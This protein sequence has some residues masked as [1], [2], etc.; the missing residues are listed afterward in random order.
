[1]TQSLH[2][3][4]KWIAKTTGVDITKIRM[5][6]VKFSLYGFKVQGVRSTSYGTRFRLPGYINPDTIMEGI[7]WRT[8]PVKKNP[9]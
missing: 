1:M 2:S 6:F 3:V 9:L 8:V 5:L 4:E 7:T